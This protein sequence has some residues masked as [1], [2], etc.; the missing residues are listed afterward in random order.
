VFLFEASRSVAEL[1]RLKWAEPTWASK[2]R[3]PTLLSFWRAAAPRNWHWFLAWSLVASVPLAIAF[4]WAY[5]QSF[6]WIVFLEFKIILAML[7]LLPGF[8]VILVYY[9]LSPFLRT[10][11]EV[12]VG[13]LRYGWQRYSLSD[14]DG[15]AVDRNSIGRPRL[16]LRDKSGREQFIGIRSDVDLVSLERMCGSA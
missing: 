2:E 4:A 7:V 13:R 10:P 12:D 6:L 5:K 14:F 9:A 3:Y 8:L 16:V 11:V 1:T 15:V